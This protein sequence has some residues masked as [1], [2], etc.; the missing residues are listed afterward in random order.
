MS[1]QHADESSES[2]RSGFIS[3]R[4]IPVLALLALQFLG[5]SCKA[6]R[7]MSDMTYMKESVQVGDTVYQIK[8]TGS[9]QSK[10]A[11]KAFGDKNLDEA[12][13]QL[14]L[15]IEHD[16][17]EPAHYFYLGVAHELNGDLPM[18]LENYELAVE[19]GSRPRREYTASVARVQETLG[20]SP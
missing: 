17:V 6:V 15:A 1:I 20:V 11:V 12:I 9:P 18:A 16:P 13:K 14:K 5:L 19:H 3:L 2:T 10:E 4:V 7:K 8:E